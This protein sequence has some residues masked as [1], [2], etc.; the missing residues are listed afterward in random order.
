MLYV[1]TKRVTQGVAKPMN[2]IE[3][4]RKFLQSLQELAGRSAWDWKRCPKCGDTLTHKNGSYT[5]RP[6]YLD[7]R[8]PEGYNDIGVTRA[9]AATQSSSTAGEGEL[10]CAGSSPRRSG[11]LATR[12]DIAA[13]DGRGAALMDGTSGSVAVVAPPGS[14]IIRAVLSGSKYGASLARWCREERPSERGRAT[15][16]DSSYAGRGH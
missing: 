2:I 9:A 4:G 12:G 11:S 1:V 15:D 8:K 16:R 13:A 14:T 7:G 6:W 3:R 10:V 5:R